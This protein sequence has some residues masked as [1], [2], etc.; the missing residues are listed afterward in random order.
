MSNNMIKAMLAFVPLA[1]ADHN[2]IV[3]KVTPE[4]IYAA[5]ASPT[6]KIL[7]DVNDTVKIKMCLPPSALGN[8]HA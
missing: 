1:M 7:M 4:S 8:W 2:E 5:D 6:Y 3:R